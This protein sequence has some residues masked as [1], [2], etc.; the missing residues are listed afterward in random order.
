MISDKMTT[1]LNKQINAELYSAYL[2][3]SM[4]A[5]ALH[6]GLK[7]AANWFRVQAQEEMVHAQKF[8]DYVNTQGARVVLAAIDGPPDKFKSLQNMFEEALKHEQKVTS[9]IHKLASMAK[10]EDDHATGNFLQWFVTE[11]VE[12]EENA[13]D[14]LDKIKLAGGPGPGLFMVDNELAAR[15][16]VP[17]PAAGAAAQ[18]A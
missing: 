7:G 10:A 13:R 14:V 12:E 3:M 11:Q 9:L 8:Y 18:Q 16:F 5:D 15:V 6:G 17:P 2:Y 4:S 1:A